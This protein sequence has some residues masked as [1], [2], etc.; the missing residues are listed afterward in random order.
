MKSFLERNPVTIGVVGVLTCAAVA[1]IAF[2]ANDLP[3]IG[4]GTTYTAYFSEAAGLKPSDEVSVA[5]VKVGKVDTVALVG[6]RV[7]VTFQVRDAWVGDN[8]TASIEIKTL[9]GQKYL[10]LDPQGSAAQDPGKA[11]ARTI[12]PYDVLDALNGLA[13]SVGQ[14][15]TG[16]LAKSFQ[17]ITDTFRNAPS[18]IKSTLDG[19]ATLSRTI[20][21]RDQQLAQLLSNTKKI[22]QTVA[23]RNDQFASLIKD[24]SALLTEVQKRREAISALLSGSRQLGVQLAGLVADNSAQLGPTLTQLDKV[25]DVLQRN[26]DNLDKGLKLIGPYYRLLDNALGNGRWID[27]YICGLVTAD[28]SR[29]CTGGGR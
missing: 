13:T 12:A 24:G 3:F 29:N 6:N 18:Q 20:S 11:I 23:D 17:V 22:S 15:D 14:I 19:L 8:T 7:R 9:L 21:S 27:T 28:S 2:S 5:G 25:T 16:Q 1:G 10:E 4:G 26:Q